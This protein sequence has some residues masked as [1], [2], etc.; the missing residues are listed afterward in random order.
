M[1]NGVGGKGQV[2]CS[3]WRVAGGSVSKGGSDNA[4]GFDKA[5]SPGD[6]SKVGL[7]EEDD[8]TRHVQRLLREHYPHENHVKCELWAILGKVMEASA[9]Q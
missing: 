9:S 1:C 4:G 8:R 3:V 5:F 2:A 6:L 7:I